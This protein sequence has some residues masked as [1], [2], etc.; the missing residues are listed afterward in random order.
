MAIDL[1]GTA[2]TLVQ[3]DKGIL[4]ADETPGIIGKRFEALGIPSTEATRRAY[5]ELLITAPELQ[6]AISGVILQD[7][8]FRQ[9]ISTGLPFPQALIQRGMLPGIK[10]DTGAKPL[11]NAPGE[12]VTEG[13]DGLRERIAEYVEL[14]AHF[15]KW[16]AV[17]SIGSGIPTRVC[18]AAN[19]HGLARYAALCQEG[20]LIPIVEPEVLIDGDHTIDACYA[21]SLTTW[22][23]VFAD[24]VDQGVALDAMVLKP[25]MILPGRQHSVEASVGEVAEST[26]RGLRH[27]VPAAVPGIAFL[28][29]G[30][31]PELATHHMQAI[32]AIGPQPWQLTFSYGRALQD[33]ALS[34]WKGQARNVGQAQAALLHRTRCVAAARSGTYNQAMEAEYADDSLLLS[35]AFV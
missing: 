28:S 30:Q 13:L 35:I 8:T 9:T 27:A 18:I 5:R 25:S 33:A 21:A 20:G 10:V 3:A 7:E 31:S 19:A 12:K 23:A 32:S 15:A 1:V 4:A 17:I 6:E 24:L 34:A 14:G 22:R 26:V 16:R 2:R 29:G 11:T